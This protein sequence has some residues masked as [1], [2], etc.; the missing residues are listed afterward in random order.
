MISRAA[1]TANSDGTLTPELCK[2]GVKLLPQ[3]EVIVEHLWFET[4]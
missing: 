2:G 3:A 4:K 1:W